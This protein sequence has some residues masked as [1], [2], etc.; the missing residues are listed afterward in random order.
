M[1]WQTYFRS[2]DGEWK[3]SVVL[4]DMTLEEATD[5]V[6]NYESFEDEYKIEEAA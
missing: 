2:E 3:E 4:E 6:L 1:N 5:W